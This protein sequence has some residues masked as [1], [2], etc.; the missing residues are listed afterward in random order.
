MLYYRNWAE[1][2]KVSAGNR[3]TAVLNFHIPTGYIY[4]IM[5]RVWRLPTSVQTMLP[6][7]FQGPTSDANPATSSL[8]YFAEELK[9]SLAFFMS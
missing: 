2:D 3:I 7:T 6:H 5:N 4:N 9:I 1:V 8:A